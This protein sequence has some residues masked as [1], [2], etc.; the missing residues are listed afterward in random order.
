MESAALT[1][2]DPGSGIAARVRAV[3]VDTRRKV[4]LRRAV[5][6]LPR[7]VPGLPHVPELRLLL[8]AAV[9][10]RGAR[11]AGPVLRGLPRPDRASARDRRRR[12]AVAAGGG[13]GPRVGGDDARVV[14]VA[15]VGD[16][17]A[18]A[19]RLHA[20]GRR[21]RRAAAADALRLRVPRRARLRRRAVHGA[22]R[23]GGGDGGA[24]PAPRLAGVRAAR[25]GGAAAAGGVGPGRAVLPLD[26]PPRHVGR[27]RA[28]RRAG[29]DRAAAVGGGRLRRHRRPAVLAALHELLG[30]GPRAPADAGGDPLGAAVVLREHRQAAGAARRARRARVRGGAAPRRA[31]DAARAAA[32]RDRHVRADRDRRP[33][34][35]R[36]LPDRR[37]AALLVFAAVAVGGFTMLRPGRLRTAWATRGA[38]ARAGRRRL[39]RDP[40]RP[41][42]ASP[43][44]CSSAATPTPR[45][46]TS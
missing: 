25:A 27:A 9:G 17:P 32:E 21:D 1:R 41:R 39:H 2:P 23:V 12:A 34:G 28:L 14:P 45:S 42:R 30:R 24:A 5:R 7:R 15:G 29:R 43:T 18:R 40:R 3:S 22:R 20:A 38:A 10:P 4:A 46:C 44:S 36:A 31:V 11:S 6:R 35:D 13:R 16:L 19:G 33:V 26:E 8:L 37:G